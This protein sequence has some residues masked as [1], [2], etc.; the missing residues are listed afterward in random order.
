M[1][2]F[3]HI[4]YLAVLLAAN[5][6]YTDSQ[7]AK[8]VGNTRKRLVEDV[9]YFVTST[10]RVHWTTNNETILNQINALKTLQSKV[11]QTVDGYRGYEINQKIDGSSKY[12]KRIPKCTNPSLEIDILKDRRSEC[13]QYVPESLEEAVSIVPG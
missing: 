1:I 4:L 7:A 3:V 6:K 11:F 8:K 13:G 12:W 9:I 5:V 10:G 2:M